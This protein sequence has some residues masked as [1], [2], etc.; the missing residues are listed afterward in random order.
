[1]S[2]IFSTLP[3]DLI[4]N[5]MLFD[6]RF[7]LRNG[8]IVSVIP[9]TDYRYSLLKSIIPTFHSIAT[10]N[11]LNNTG[12]YVRYEYHLPDLY[13]YETREGRDILQIYLGYPNED[14]TINFV[15]SVARWKPIVFPEKFHS[16][17]NE[18]E[19]VYTLSSCKIK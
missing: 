2:S 18:Y 10:F 14:N 3:T 8:E 15:I 1:M 6:E 13:T 4:T 19:Y 7:K 17:A 16:F 11:P 5:I 9:K 12:H